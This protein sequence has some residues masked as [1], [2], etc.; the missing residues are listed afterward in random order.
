[1]PGIL[2]TLFPSTSVNASAGATAGPI[3]SPP[4]PN[5]G[6][7]V[8]TSPVAP[9]V[10]AT[11]P[12]SPLDEYKSLWET[13]TGADGKPIVHTDP[14]ATPLL[15]FD[16]IKIAESAKGLNFTSK[17][18][19]TLAGKALGGDAQALSDYVNA[20]VQAAVVGITTSQGNLI[21]N[22]IDA[23]NKRV[24]STLP[25]H[26][27]RVQLGQQSVENSALNHP[28][29]APLVQA[30]TQ[31]EFNKNPNANPQDVHKKI[32]DYLVSLGQVINENDPTKVAA[33]T[34]AAAGEVDWLA[35]G[36]LPAT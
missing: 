29:V 33:S 32:Q 4:P 24:N 7:P 34:K 20:A 25:E 13:P 18:D 16:P 31:A 2:G 5:G 15:N 19:P 23:N 1:M 17:I 22:A 9:P 6:A 11:P 8:T 14:L 27:R 30:L 28:A 35:Y 26:I 10:A 21:N 3:N 12:S 36:G